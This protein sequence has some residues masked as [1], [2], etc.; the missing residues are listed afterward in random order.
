MFVQFVFILRRTLIVKFN[1]YFGKDLLILSGNGVASI[2]VFR[3]KASSVLQVVDDDEDDLNESI[4]KVAKIIALECK[5]LKQDGNSYQ[6]R[7]SF[8]AAISQCSS[9]LL[10][11]LKQVSAKLDASM[12]AALIGNIVTSMTT[13]QATTLQASESTY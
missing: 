10:L 9:T 6:T 7:I 4:T 5:Q 1:T 2:L 8:N 13:N 12:P 11:L 3:S